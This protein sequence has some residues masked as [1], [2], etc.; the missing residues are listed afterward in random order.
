MTYRRSVLEGIPGIG[1]K[2]RANLLRH[3]GS[4]KRIRAAPLEELCAVTGMTRQAARNLFEALEEISP[5]QT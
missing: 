1:T 4:L 3:F 2:R 5:R